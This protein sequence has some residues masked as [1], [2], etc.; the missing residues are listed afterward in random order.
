MAFSL[1]LIVLIT[2][3]LELPL[4]TQAGC[5]AAPREGPCAGHTSEG[6]QVPVSNFT[7]GSPSLLPQG[8]SHTQSCRGQCW[9]LDL[10]SIL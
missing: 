1:T 7:W 9:T 3:E 2:E 8:L 5:R 10:A 6:H 4:L